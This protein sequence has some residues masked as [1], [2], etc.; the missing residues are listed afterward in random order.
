M[1]LERPVEDK[2]HPRSGILAAMEMLHQC[3]TLNQIARAA[4]A[5]PEKSASGQSG[6]RAR[7][8]HGIQDT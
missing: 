2:F 5:D 6:K 8:R 4:L 7:R 1:L 3:E